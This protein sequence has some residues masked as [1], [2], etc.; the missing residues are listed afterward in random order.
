MIQLFRQFQRKQELLQVLLPTAPDN[1]EVVE[2]AVAPHPAGLY[3]VNRCNIRDRPVTKE[4]EQL[5][6]LR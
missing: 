4:E 5:H 2:L 1:W 3:R 6:L